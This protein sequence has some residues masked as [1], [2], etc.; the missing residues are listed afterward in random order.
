MCLISQYGAYSKAFSTYTD[1]LN[2]RL[3]GEY[4]LCFEI[5]ETFNIF[6]MSVSQAEMPCFVPLADV[7]TFNALITAAPEVKEKYNEKWE[8]IMVCD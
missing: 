6:Q 4:V 8:L 7:H 2:N 5:L 3:K 1:L